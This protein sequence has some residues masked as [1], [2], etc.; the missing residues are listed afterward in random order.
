L[1]LD[2]E[3]PIDTARIWT[4]SPGLGKRG[5]RVNSDSARSA[6]KPIS[7]VSTLLVS[8]DSSTR[9]VVSTS[10]FSSLAWGATTQGVRQVKRSPASNPDTNCAF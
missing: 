2:R 6:A 4:S 3:R 1:N 10:S 5:S 8:S 7:V 9:S